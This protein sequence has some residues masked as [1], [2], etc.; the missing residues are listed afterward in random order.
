MR[1]MWERLTEIAIA[2]LNIPHDA[3]GA[4][5]LTVEVPCCALNLLQGL[6]QVQLGHV[7]SS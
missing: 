7:F 5:T 2:F 6:N 1:G 3:S 4:L